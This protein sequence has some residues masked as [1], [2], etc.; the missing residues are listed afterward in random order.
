MSNARPEFLD[1]GFVENGQKLLK[2]VMEYHNNIRNFPVR[3]TP[4][5]KPGYLRSIL[6]SKANEQP[7]DFSSLYSDIVN[8]ILPGIVHWQSPKFHGYFPTGCSYPSL[9]ADIISAAFSCIG[10]NWSAC[11]IYTE[12]E[13]VMVDWI[14][15]EMGLAKKFLFEAKLGGG[16]II[17]GSASEAVTVSIIAAREKKISEIL[18]NTS[19]NLTYYEI[20]SKLRAYASDQV[21]SSVIKAARLSAIR[22]TIIESES[23]LRLGGDRLLEHIKKDTNEGLFPFFASTNIGTT[24]TCAFD[25]VETIGKICQEHKIW[26]HADAAYSGVL[27]FIEEFRKVLPKI[28]LVQ[29][30]AFNPHKLMDICFDCSMLWIEDGNAM[31]S[32]LGIYP[33]YLKSDAQDIIEFKDWQVPLGRRFRS[34]KIYFH[35]KL[36]GMEHIRSQIRNVKKL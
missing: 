21:H 31:K 32:A 17:Q 15:K 35:I 9:Y 7:V 13:I 14:A 22:L 30:F 10:F 4:A 29:S 23:D 18:A 34:L 28:D 5:L 36:L 6:P 26:L 33:T 2:F 24:N 1:K 16:G 12:L 20:L 19:Q 11:P 25:D 27:F 3:P 8:I